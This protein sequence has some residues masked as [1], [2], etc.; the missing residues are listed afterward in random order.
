MYLNKKITLGSRVIEENSKPYLIAEIGVNHEGSMDTAKYLIDLAKEEE[1]MRLN[2]K[3]IKLK[4]LLQKIHL[5][6]GI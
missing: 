5:H 1:L 2:F 3:L 6:I 4:I